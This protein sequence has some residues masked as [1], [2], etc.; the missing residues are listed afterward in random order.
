[1]FELSAIPVN[2]S[3]EL[4]KYNEVHKRRK[5]VGIRFTVNSRETFC[6]NPL[7]MMYDECSCIK[8][9]DFSASYFGD[10][11]LDIGKVATII[12]NIW[13]GPNNNHL[14]FLLIIGFSQSSRLVVAQ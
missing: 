3:I 11:T 1:M 6:P 9:K 10:S 2:M 7:L 5:L 13:E 12:F 4:N 8:G 14:I